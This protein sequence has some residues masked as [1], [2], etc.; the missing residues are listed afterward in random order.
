MQPRSESPPV[1]SLDPFI[2]EWSMRADFPGA[3][4]SDL[5]GLTV[6]QWTAGGTLLVQR[7]EVPHPDAPDG[8]AIIRFD[9]G[10]DSY[11]QHYFD[12]RGVARVYEMSFSGGVWKLTRTTADLSPLDFSQRF[13]G[14]FGADG[15]TIEGRWE[16]SHDGSAWEHDFDLVYTRLSAGKTP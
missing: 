7:W 12:S 9:D 14:T 2:G 16:I 6:F 8:I 5:R 15:N 13:T 4:S 11:L 1:A 10:R 3:P